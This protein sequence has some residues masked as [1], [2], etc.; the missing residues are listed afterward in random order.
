MDA[1]APLHTFTEAF[2]PRPNDRNISTHHIATL[3]EN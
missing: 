3:F 2:K 1:A